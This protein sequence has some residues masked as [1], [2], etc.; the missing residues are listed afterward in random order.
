[1]HKIIALLGLV[2]ISATAA[3]AASNDLTT[4]LDVYTNLE[5]GADIADKDLTSAQAACKRA[6]ST[7]LTNDAKRKTDAALVSIGEELQRRGK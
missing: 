7:T 3:H 4:C 2:F 1:M 6:Q 5:A